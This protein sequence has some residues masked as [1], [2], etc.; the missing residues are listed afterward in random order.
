MA[1]IISISNQKGGVGKSTTSQALASGL[2][3][4][5]NKKVL[6]VDLDSQ[7]NATYATGE[8]DIDMTVYEVMRGMVDIKNAIY[9]T[10]FIDILPASKKL[11]QLDVELTEVG[12]E[13]KL[14]ESLEEIKSYYD[15]IVIDTPPALGILTV[16]ALTASDYIIIP[17][18]ADV[19]SLQGIGMLM[20]TCNNIK[21]YSNKDLKLLGV[22][23]TRFNARTILSNEMKDM[24]NDTAQQIGTFLYDTVIREGIAIKEAQAIRQDI[25]NYSSKSNAA[26]DYQNFMEEL[27]ERIL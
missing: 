17:S 8:K 22:L 2:A 21:K 18:Q 7:G 5:K 26:T 10:E 12:K 24:I 25:F 3:H 15:F 16:N 20:D 23:L 11:T 4:I 6:L 27:L 9:E 14:K 13:Y 19:F 1:I